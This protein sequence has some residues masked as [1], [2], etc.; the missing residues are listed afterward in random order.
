MKHAQGPLFVFAFIT[1]CQFISCAPKPEV[2]IV[3][4]DTIAED[5]VKMALVI[6]EYDNDFIDA[7]YGPEEWKPTIPPSDSARVFPYEEL[8]WQTIELVSALEELDVEDYDSLEMLRFKY[9]H[10]QL[11]AVKTKINMIA[12]ESLPFDVETRALYDAVAP[13]FDEDHYDR[14]LKELDE[15]LPGSGNLSV[16]YDAFSADFVIPKDKLDTV[17]KT[18]I[19][20]ARQRTLSHIN[21]PEKENF[22]L[23][24]VTDKPWSGYNWYKGNGLSLI[25]INTDLPIYIERAIDLA[26]HEGY[27]GHHAYNVSLEQSLVVERGW[28]EFSIY[29]LFSPQSLIAE[30][31]ANYGIEVAFPGEE[32]RKYE[33]E[34]LFPLAGIDPDKVDLYYDI[35][36]IRSKLVYSENEAAMF[37]L[38]GQI[39]RKEAIDW[40]IKYD[41]YTQE[42]AMQRTQF[43]DKYRSYIIN[44][45]YG[46]DLVKNFV[47][48][49][50]GS[51]SDPEKRWELFNQILNSPV[52]ASVIE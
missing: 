33:K 30:G 39:S 26:C 12:G 43:F 52:T 3:S 45:N 47:E 44:Y 2:E 13:H 46:K 20:E 41:L 22:T 38:N 9:L 19:A 40:L 32:R 35:Q 51:D 29:L 24:Y 18:A 8:K 6:G 36:E 4:L 34:V 15:L 28:P 49:G 23:E 48:Q 7:Y 25:Q 37:Y 10:N 11:I 5:Y 1:I 50:G 16:R 14:L 42:R 17:F 27:P 31:T 21:L